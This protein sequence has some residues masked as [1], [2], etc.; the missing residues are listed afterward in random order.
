MAQTPEIRLEKRGNHLWAVM[1]GDQEVEVFAS[2]VKADAMVGRLRSKAACQKR[3]CLCCKAPFLSWGPGN[4]L[5]DTCKKKDS[6]N[7]AV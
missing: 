4:R 5:C 7:G 2:W 3:K 6:F 1:S